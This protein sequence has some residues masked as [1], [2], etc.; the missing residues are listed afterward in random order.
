MTAATH[1]CPHITP[2]SE[3]PAA[4]RT[5]DELLQVCFSRDEPRP[6]MFKHIV[7]PGVCRSLLTCRAPKKKRV[8]VHNLQALSCSFAVLVG[9]ILLQ[10]SLC[11]T[12][13]HLMCRHCAENHLGRPSRPPV[14]RYGDCRP[15]TTGKPART[16]LCHHL[17]ES[18]PPQLWRKPWPFGYATCRCSMVSLTNGQQTIAPLGAALPT[19]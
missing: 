5:A 6:F 14:A 3:Q 12:G 13:H 19:G 11:R 17:L 15:C 1:T 2:N 16:A 7:V 9:Q 10:V 18:S 4:M 8:M